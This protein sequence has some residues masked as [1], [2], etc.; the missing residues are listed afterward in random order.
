MQCLMFLP[1]AC[2]VPL[3]VRQ[4]SPGHVSHEELCS[5]GS[6]GGDS[7]HG[8]PAEEHGSQNDHLTQSWFH[9]KP[10]L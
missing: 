6:L 4:P 2:K 7:A 3:L 8:V 1:V 5:G 9:R 10:R